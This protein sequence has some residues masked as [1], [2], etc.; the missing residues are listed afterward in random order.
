MQPAQRSELEDNDLAAATMETVERIRP[1]LWSIAAVIG[2]VFAAIGLWAVITGQRAAA[3]ATGWRDGLA[4]ERDGNAAG[5]EGVAR[6][7]AGTPAAE[8]A[9][10]TVATL[11]FDEGVDLLFANRAQ[12]TKRLTDAAARYAALLQGRTNPII[13][14]RAVFGLAKTNEAL[15]DLT[16]ARKGYEAVVRDYPDGACAALAGSRA[17][18]LA[19]PAT[20][21]WYAWFVGQDFAAADTAPVQEPAGSPANATPP[22]PP[23]PAAD[24]APAASPG[25]GA[26]PSE[27]SPSPAA[28]GGGAGTAGEPAP[29]AAPGADAGSK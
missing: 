9:D 8:W 22:A 1:H 15:G 18:A 11:A 27:T 23:K 5:L 25:T 4:A 10:L 19:R 28:A 3:L 26:P 7:Y 16:A 24:P 6:Q 14:E 13:A 21:E 2:L 29:G 20:A 12:A 17:A